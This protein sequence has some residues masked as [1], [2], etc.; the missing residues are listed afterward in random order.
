[1]K[2][3]FSFSAFSIGLYRGSEV[4]V[5]SE[6]PFQKFPKG[7]FVQEGSS[8]TRFDHGQLEIKTFPIYTPPYCT[9]FLPSPNFLNPNIIQTEWTD[10]IAK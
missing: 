10:F 7:I 1:M 3:K 6:D 5:G 8:G 9:M 4:T 2:F